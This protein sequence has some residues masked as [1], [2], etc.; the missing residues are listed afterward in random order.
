VSINAKFYGFV[1]T[2]TLKLSQMD[3]SVRKMYPYRN[4][5][6]IQSNAQ[7]GLS[8]GSGKAMISSIARCPEQD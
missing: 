8:Y 2:V 3:S 6:Q 1:L 5:D 7:E 4:Q